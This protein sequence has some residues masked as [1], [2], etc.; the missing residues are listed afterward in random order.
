MLMI[1][2]QILDI[3]HVCCSF[4]LMFHFCN[5]F[6][7]LI[8][9]CKGIFGCSLLKFRHGFRAGAVFSIFLGI[10]MYLVGLGYLALSL[11]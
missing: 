2:A 5:I 3:R 1:G 11:L 7:M 4:A 8:V 10:L 6:W 9:S